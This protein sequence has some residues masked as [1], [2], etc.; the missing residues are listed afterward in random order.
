MVITTSGTI[1]TFKTPSSKPI[2]SL[3]VYFG[4]IQSGSGDPSPNNVRTIS[5]KTS[6]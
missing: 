2:Q 4:P 3:K 1:A 6:I 5:G